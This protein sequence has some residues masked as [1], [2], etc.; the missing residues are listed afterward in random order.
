MI[1]AISGAFVGTMGSVASFVTAMVLSGSVCGSLS[2]SCTADTALLAKVVFWVAF[3]G[4][5]AVLA[6]LYVGLLKL[7]R[8]PRPWS[9]LVPGTVLA[10]APFAIPGIWDLKGA[11][12]LPGA[13]FALA[14]LITGFRKRPQ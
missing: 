6:L 5:L 4:G 12:L 7:G 14:G 13:A 11:I 10:A 8:Q 3:L 2:E 9:V 1:R